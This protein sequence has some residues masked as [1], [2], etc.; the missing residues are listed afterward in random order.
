MRIWLLW[1]RY[2]WRGLGALL[3]VALALVLLALFGV[4]GPSLSVRLLGNVD[5]P[6]AA[7]AQGLSGT[8][9][10]RSS[11]PATGPGTLSDPNTSILDT[12]ARADAGPRTVAAAQ[13]AWSADEITKHQNALLAAINC[14]RQE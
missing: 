7:A 12:P 4:G 3:I 11:D 9:L 14:A 2:R 10:P 13:A 1:L 6:R 5:A 8:I